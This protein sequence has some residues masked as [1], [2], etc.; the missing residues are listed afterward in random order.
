MVDLYVPPSI[1]T[2]YLWVAR[3]AHSVARTSAIVVWLLEQHVPLEVQSFGHNNLP[4]M[5]IEWIDRRN[6]KGL[7]TE[8]PMKVYVAKFCGVFPQKHG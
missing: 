2:G 5:C 3:S 8:K 1:F 6:A 4:F 7:I